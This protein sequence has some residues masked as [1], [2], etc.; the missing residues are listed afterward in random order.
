MPTVLTTKPSITDS[1]PIKEIKEPTRE[2][3]FNAIYW[4]ANNTERVPCAVGPTASGKTYGMMQMAK[5]RNGE[6]ITVLASQHTPDEITGFQAIVNGELVAQ[7]PY[8]F[9]EAQKVLDSGKNVFILFDELGFARTEV[10][11]ALLTYFRD[12]SIHGHKLVES[13]NAKAY[14]VA[15]SNPANFMPQFKTR[16]VFFHVPADR[17]YLVAMAKTPFAKKVAASSPLYNDKDSAYSNIPPA[18]PETADASSV[19]ALNALNR[20]FWE[21]TEEAR[22]LILQGLVP[23]QQLIELLKETTIDATYLANAPDEY[24]KVLTVLSRDE[25]HSVINAVTDALSAIED[26]AVVVATLLNTI[27][28]IFKDNTAQDIEMYYTTERREEVANRIMRIPGELVHKELVRRKM[29]DFN[30]SGQ[31]KGSLYDNLTQIIA[32]HE[33]NS[34]ND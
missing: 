33:A 25:K 16:C 4:I 30:K 34:T 11:G 2:D 9:N 10:I 28:N 17:R 15:A 20:D 6:V 23:H 31:A 24:A 3:I 5:Q 32:Y 7:P 22:G 19:E 27:E 13:D 26:D 29:L 21:L 14:V 18:P 12:R 1:T 8:W